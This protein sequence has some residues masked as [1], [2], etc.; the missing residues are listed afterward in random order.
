MNLKFEIT[1]VCTVKNVNR[2]PTALEIADAI[3]HLFKYEDM[4]AIINVSNLEEDNENV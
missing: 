1:G 4:K 2:M 3:E